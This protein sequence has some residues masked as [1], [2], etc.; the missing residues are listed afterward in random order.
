MGVN[1]P[2]LSISLCHKYLVL[3]RMPYAVV[4]ALQV[5]AGA[6]LR[7]GLPSLRVMEWILQFDTPS[8]DM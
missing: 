3:R 6:L 5:I 7:S 8:D 2:V 1:M 4:T